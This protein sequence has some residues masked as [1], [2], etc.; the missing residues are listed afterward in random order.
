MIFIRKNKGGISQ[1]NHLN[2]KKLNVYFN[3]KLCN[4]WNK[5]ICL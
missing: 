1:L 4:I 3:K 5:Y 2:L